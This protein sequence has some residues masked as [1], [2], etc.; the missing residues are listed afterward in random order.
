MSTRTKRPGTKQVLLVWLAIMYP[1]GVLI[2][3]AG[4]HFW[5]AWVK[6]KWGVE[7]EDKDTSEFFYGPAI[8]LVSAGLLIL[9][10]DRLWEFISRRR[11]RNAS[12][13]SLDG[14]E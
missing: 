11:N 10:V 9:C 2:F 6:A 12:P 4:N 7:I 1:I 5:K 13:E 3:F 14:V 8:T